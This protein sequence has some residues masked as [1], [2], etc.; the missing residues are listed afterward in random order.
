MLKSV[1]SI[2][3][4]FIHK[5]SKTPYDTTT[6]ALTKVAYKI[7]LLLVLKWA[8]YEANYDNQYCNQ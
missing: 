6:E 4:V 2:K 7:G 3:L 1:K 5:I 8:F